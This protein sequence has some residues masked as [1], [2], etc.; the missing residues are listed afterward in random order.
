MKVA[1]LILVFFMSG[2]AT[3]KHHWYEHPGIVLGGIGYG[4]VVGPENV[5]IREAER[6]AVKNGTRQY[7]DSFIP[8]YIV[9][10]TLHAATG[11]T[12]FTLTPPIG[13]WYLGLSSLVGGAQFY[14]LNAWDGDNSK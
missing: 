11:I 1:I 6:R 4:A 9:G 10:T 13:W 14:E 7:S 5:S 2:C 12:L 3:V 8:T